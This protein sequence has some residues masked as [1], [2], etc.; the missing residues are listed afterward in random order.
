MMRRE[1]QDRI[2]KANTLEEYFMQI[3]QATGVNTLEEMVEGEVMEPLV[4]LAKSNKAGS[5][6]AVAALL[7]LQHSY[8]REVVEAGGVDVFETCLQSESTPN[9]VVHSAGE[10]LRS[11]VL[12]K[13]EGH[14]AI[15]ESI[16]TLVDL[17]SSGTPKAQAHVAL[18]YS[19][20]WRDA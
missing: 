20:T 3:R 6:H 17:L 7:V 8:P 15:I 1:N 11:L 5:A 16:T 12:H 13:P 19:P 18:E 10:A 14:A 4:E 2:D 9:V